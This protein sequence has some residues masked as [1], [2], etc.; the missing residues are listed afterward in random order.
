MTEPLPILLD[1]DL[2]TDVDDAIALAFLARDPRCD[3][4]GVTT[5]NGRVR[6]RAELVQGL[7]DLLGRGDL[8]V[9][10]GAA[11]PLGGGPHE[12]MPVGIIA[13]GPRGEVPDDAPTAEDVYVE[14]LR[15]TT[16]PVHVCGV[17]A[18][19]N[20]AAVLTAHPEL[21]DA[22][23]GV[24]LMG[25]C[26]RDYGFVPGGP[27]V[28]ASM[29]F[30]LNGD[31]LAAAA[32]LAL[33]L[34]LRLVPQDTTNVLLLDEDARSA[35]AGAGEL[36]AALEEQME[37]WVGFLRSRTDRP[38]IPHVRLHDPLTVVGLVAP[39]VEL[40]ATVGLSLHGTSGS[41]R[42]VESPTGRPTTVVRDA[43]HPALVKALVAAITG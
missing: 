21:H 20:V 31:P 9:G 1:T 24:H 22:V 2:G 17:G 16:T 14:V 18:F 28:P 8:P 15:S 39:E 43:D 27:K 40:R 36:G 13:R 38:D 3:L 41:A 11:D 30:N 34:P 23:A 19:T 7:L 35:I 26:L 32:C 37:G 29:E 10:L 4:R 5:V 12:T 6:R 25:G 33:P 42:F